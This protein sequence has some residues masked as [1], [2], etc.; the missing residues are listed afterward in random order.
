MALIIALLVIWHCCWRRRSPPKLGDLAPLPDPRPGIG[1]CRIVESG[2]QKG[3]LKVAVINYG[4]AD[5]PPSTTTVTFNSGETVELAT[6]TI[7]AGESVELEPV[8]IPKGC[9][10]P[11]CHFRIVVDSK[12]D[13][14]ESDKSNNT[15]EYFCLG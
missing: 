2:P 9:F 3:R 1:F 14:I 4:N 6:P 15:A 13:V 5:A 11:D 7:R 12:N 10:S 8:E